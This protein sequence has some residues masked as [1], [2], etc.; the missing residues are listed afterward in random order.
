M[1]SSDTERA[2]IIPASINIESTRFVK[3]FLRY[4]L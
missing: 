2:D 4:S 3:D 1:N